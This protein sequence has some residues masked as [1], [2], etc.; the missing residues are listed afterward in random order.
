MQ[1]RA[2]QSISKDRTAA[3]GSTFIEIQFKTMDKVDHNDDIKHI[4]GD[5]PVSLGKIDT[6]QDTSKEKSSKMIVFENSEI[7]LIENSNSPHAVFSF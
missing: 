7:I 5:K 6:G 3:T 2:Q 1:A 4:T